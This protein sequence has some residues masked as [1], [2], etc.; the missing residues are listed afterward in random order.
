[1]IKTKIS[2]ISQEPFYSILIVL[3][4]Q[5]SNIKTEF[6]PHKLLVGME[7]HTLLMEI[8]PQ[9]LIV[10]WKPQDSKNHNPCSKKWLDLKNNPD[11]V[12]KPYANYLFHQS[13][14]E[15][16]NTFILSEVVIT[17]TQKEISI[18]KSCYLYQWTVLFWP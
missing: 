12:T 3:S 8:L 9:L 18:N 16:W 2:K 14:K 11:M 5:R 10:P 15:N 6:L 4:N 17:L 1:L 7:F 13:K